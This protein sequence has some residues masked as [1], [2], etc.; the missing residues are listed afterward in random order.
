MTLKM[1]DELWDEVL[2]QV[3]KT[4]PQSDS[5]LLKRKYISRVDCDKRKM[6]HWVVNITFNKKRFNKTFTDKKNGGKHN[7]LLAAVAYRQKI[8][9]ENNI[10][11]MK[12][13]K[14]NPYDETKKG[15]CV[16]TKKD[17]K[18][19]YPVV[20]CYWH[21]PDI[22]GKQRRRSKSFSIN[23]HGL[24]RAQ[25]RAKKYRETKLKELYGE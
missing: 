15:I 14:K 19:T 24:K 13:I 3:E 11:F 22:N 20:K 1:H 9:E 7:A 21:E 10:V 12:G 2:A 6:H 17:G 8:I 4:L 5:A 18:Y 25:Q 23:K 16:T